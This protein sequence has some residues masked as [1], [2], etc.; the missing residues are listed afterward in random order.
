MKLMG[1]LKQACGK[2]IWILILSMIP[3]GMASAQITSATADYVDSVSYPVREGWDPLFVF[4]QTNQVPRSGD[5]TA[6]LPGNGSYSFEWSRYN[7]TING[8]DPPFATETGVASSSVGDLQEGGYRVS[9]FDGASTDTTMM[10]WI[11]LDN[12]TAGV[13]KD[14]NNEV[15]PSFSTCNF[16]VVIGEVKPDTFIF[17]D[18]DSYES[19]EIPVGYK[20]KWTSDNDELKIPSDSTNL[21]FNIT[22]LPPFKDTWYILTV[23]DELGMVEVDSVFY[24][25]KVTR[26]EF[27]VEYMDKI[28]GEFD[29]DL[30]GSW[31]DERGSTDA[32]LTVRFINESRNGNSYEWVF[33][34]TLG[35]VKQNQ[36]TTTLEEM[37]EFTYE[38]ADEYY[39]PY[40]V[41]TSKFDC[42][43]TFL[44]E[45]PIFVVPSILEIPN[46]FTPNGDPLNDRW[47]FKHQSLKHCRVT[48][49]DRTGKVVYK[50]EIDDIYTWEGWDG[51]VHDSDREAPEGQYYFVVE[52]LG[53]DGIEYRD[54]NIIENWKRKRANKKDQG[55]G[56]TSPETPSDNLYTGWLYLF[57]HTGVY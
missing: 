3:A 2:F 55:T 36:V 48:I 28:T 45:E 4:Y 43:D 57:R 29:P 54:P 27:S 22:Y 47:V 18:P 33:L 44:M 56:G 53:Y 51:K 49:V 19:L 17:Y 24:V 50:R 26:A 31:S 14:E 5:L 7:E 32:K 8:F 10:A 40:L 38:M 42:I 39:Y 37:P 34:D 6:T 25:S 13:L 1:H 35:G 46:V 9:I 12:L 20:F 16:L 52:A 21:R 15:L 41:S 23:T 11:M 30:D